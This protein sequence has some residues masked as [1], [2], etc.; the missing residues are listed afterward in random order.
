MFTERQNKPNPPVE[1]RSESVDDELSNLLERRN[2]IMQGKTLIFSS[3]A[4]LYLHHRP[5]S[6]FFFQNSPLHALML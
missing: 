6:L 4:V 5:S 1:K 3:S 2:K